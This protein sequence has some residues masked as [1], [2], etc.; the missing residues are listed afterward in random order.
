MRSVPA[1]LL[2]G[3]SDSVFTFDPSKFLCTPLVVPSAAANKP[4]SSVYPILPACC[5]LP[6]ISFMLCLMELHAWFFPSQNSFSVRRLL[7]SIFMGYSD[8]SV[9]K[10]RRHRRHGFYLWIKKIPWGRKWQPTPVFLPK[11]IFTSQKLDNLF[12]M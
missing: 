11:N 5:K 9:G 1:V 8:G 6:I 3:Y 2:T 10:C 12:T 4:A 7:F